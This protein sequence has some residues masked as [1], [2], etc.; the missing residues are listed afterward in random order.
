MWR[1]EFTPC[2]VSPSPAPPDGTLTYSVGEGKD[3]K[4]GDLQFLQKRNSL[5][6]SLPVL[7]LG[8]T[9][10]ISVLGQQQPNGLSEKGE[11]GVWGGAG[12][13]QGEISHGHPS[14]TP[15]ALTQ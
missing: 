15:S 9:V 7:V 4:S 1:P 2:P 5:A 14:R 8:P 11:A 6:K 12:H 3:W 10:M 13:G